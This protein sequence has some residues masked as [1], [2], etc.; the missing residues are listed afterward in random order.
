MLLKIGKYQKSHKVDRE[1]SSSKYSIKSF[2]YTRDSDN[3]LLISNTC[4]YFM[5][6][7][8]QKIY[9][10]KNLGNELRKFVDLGEKFNKNKVCLYTQS[11]IRIYDTIL[12]EEK[13]KFVPEW[14]INIVVK[15]KNNPDY[16]LSGQKNGVICIYDIE[17]LILLNQYQVCK[18]MINY[19]HCIG[20]SGYILCNGDKKCLVVINEEN[21]VIKENIE[22]IEDYK[23]LKKMISIDSEN[24][25][26]LG[27]KLNLLILSN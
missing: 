17:K 7:S 10:R 1:E 27:S 16:L 5:N 9:S 11:N 2:Y 15:S 19:I 25:Y 20:D 22:K 6:I 14:A 8:T 26:I 3:I 12:G 21:G 24:K 4:L 13:I 23:E 18:T